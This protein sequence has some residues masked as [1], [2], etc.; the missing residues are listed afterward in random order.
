MVKVILGD[1]N[2][3][4]LKYGSHD[5]TDTY[6]YSIFTSGFIPCILKPTR[7]THTTATL[8]DHILIN[9]VPS[10]SSSGIIIKN[11]LMM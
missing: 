3:N 1:M 7:V 9:D 10:K 2:I 8:L 5:Q 6:V 11:Q 4:M